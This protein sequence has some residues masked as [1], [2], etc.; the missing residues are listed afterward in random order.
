MRVILK[1]IHR[2]RVQLAT[3]KPRV[4]F[5]AWR[6]GPRLNAEPGT[7]EFVRQYH[8]AHLLLRRP[9]AGTLMTL[10]AEYKGSAEFGRL[11]PSSVRAYL[12]Y[13]KLLE[14]EFGD[15]PLAALE[16]R[17]IRGEFKSWRDRFANTPR[18]ADYAWSTLSRILSFSKDR[19]LIGSNPCESGGRLYSVDR[20]DK[21]W[22]DE[23]V[24][25]FLATAAP[26]LAK[27]MM[28]ALWTGQRQGDLLRLPWSAYDGSHIRLRQSKTGRR[29]TLPVGEPLRLLLDRT[30]RRSPMILTTTRGRPW[31]SDGFRTSWSKACAKAGITG[32]TFHD[33]RG[34]AVVRLALA[35]ATVPQIATFTGHSLRDVEAILDAHYLGR[36]VK[37]AEIA[38]M[39]LETRT[40]L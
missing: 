10:I 29:I 3:G 16:D 5:Y 12:S 8:E 2:V 19:G 25:G 22:R 40:K 7:P 1:G 11:S 23:D 17:R 31:T 38:V 13:I 37:L 39:K 15:L 14:D 30:V 36:D 28:L 21:I 18:K 27:A 24:I 34:S 33:L 26:E 32:L 9:K 20:T 4:Y 6:G 35:D